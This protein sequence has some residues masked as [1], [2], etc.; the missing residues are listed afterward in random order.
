MTTVAVAQGA[1]SQLLAKKQT[2]LGTQATGDYTKQRYVTHSLRTDIGNA[3]SGE[4]RGDRNVA[5]VRHANRSAS[6]DISAEL[7]Y[8]DH[9]LFLESAMFGAF[10]TSTD[11]AN[12][13]IG[14]SWQYLSIEDGALDISQYR[15]FIDMVVS[16][17]AFQ[18]RTGADAMVKATFS[19]MGTD[20]GSPQGST[21]GGT[22]VA[23]SGNSPFDSFTGGLYDHLDIASGSELAIVSSLD[24][25]IDNGV[26]PIYSIGQ[27]TA[28]GLESGRGRVTG[29]ATLYYEDG[30]FID[31]F[32]NE[33]ESVLVTSITD[34][35]G[36]G[37]TFT[38]PRIKYSGADVPVQ[39]E[40][41][42][43]I[44]LPFMALYESA[45]GYAMRITK[46]VAS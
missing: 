13:D 12:L 34:P 43:I 44:T 5:D 16:R 33:T 31:R 9:D 8:G 41:S 36:N 7:V 30:T 17:A 45:A 23:A 11:E 19:M 10:A 2:A 6:G 21:Q 37:M 35:D 4:I 14:T 15:L 39:S 38:L 1:R 18:F 46:T 28:I 3:E 24:I 25:N 27:Q 42:R 22:A 26:N 29:Q 40:Q 20:G 32:L